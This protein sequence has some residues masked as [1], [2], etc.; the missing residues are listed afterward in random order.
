[1]KRWIDLPSYLPVSWCPRSSAPASEAR[2]R[3]AHFGIQAEVRLRRTASQYMQTRVRVTGFSGAVL[4]AHSGRPLFR[5]AYGLADRTFDV[6]NTPET[7]FRLGS[8]T[9]RLQQ[10]LFSCSSPANSSRSTILSLR[11]VPNWPAGWVNVTIRHLLNHTAGL[12][13]LT[14]AWPFADVIGL[15]RAPLPVSLDRSSI[16]PRLP[17]IAATRFHAW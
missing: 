9:N 2:L 5:A 11:V 7:K 12:P 14:T 8:V 15:S 16:W 1:M 13:R 3:D 4:V 6:L 17:K 10:L